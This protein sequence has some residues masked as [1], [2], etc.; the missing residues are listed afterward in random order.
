MKPK[1][2][3]LRWKGN[4]GYYDHGGQPRHWERLGTAEAIVL[5]RW[6]RIHN[7]EAPGRGTVDAM[8]AEYLEHPRAPI[9]PGTLRNY[10]TFRGH[11]ARVLGRE[12]PATITQAVIVRYLKTCPRKS[13]RGEIGLLSLAYVNWMDQERLDFNPCF[14]VKVKL[15]TSKRDRLLSPAE[16]EAIVQ[17]ADERVA[18]AIELAYATGLRISDVCAVRWGDFAE[19]VQTGK[20]GARQR[21]ETTEDMRALLD[22]CRALQARVASLYV[23]C[24][25]GGKRWEPAKLRKRWDKACRLAGVEDANFHDLRAAAGTEVDRQLGKRAAQLFLGH[26]N[27]QT[28]EIY[29]RDKRANSITPLT[30]K[31]A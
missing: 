2:P 27:P 14:G 8:V 16:I 23:L 10:K 26:R 15:P 28:T 4:T 29:L 3:N 12:D 18:L 31:K 5:A 19:T 21:F 9:K 25:R 22:R 1:R 24:D 20:T 17:K 30:R 11:L 6:E 13:A 7:A